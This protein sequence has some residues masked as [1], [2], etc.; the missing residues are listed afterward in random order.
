MTFN[1]GVIIGP[2]LG[3]ILSDPAGS[4]PGLFGDIEF[5]RRFPY[6]TPNLV[7]ALFLFCSLLCVWLSLEETLDLRL[8]KHDRGLELGRK[9][10]NWFSGRR[11][12]AVYMSLAGQDTTIDLDEP[13]FNGHTRSRQPSLS[14]KQPRC[15]Y[16][17]RLPF[18][19]IFTSNVVPTLTANFLLA[20]HL[21]AFSTLWFTFLSTPVYDPTKRPSSP[22]TLPRQLRFIFAGG[23]GMRPA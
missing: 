14:A 8:D 7:S 5:S 22:T 18:R 4:Y 19:R 23:P 12:G 1:V 15:R 16:T 20:F 17:Q 11:S 21:G 10:R 2:I 3:G 6:A 9:L 13:S